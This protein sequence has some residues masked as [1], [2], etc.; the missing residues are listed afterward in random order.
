MFRAQLGKRWSRAWQAH[1]PEKMLRVLPVCGEGPQANQMQHQKP[2]TAHTRSPPGYGP[3]P[4]SPCV[5]QPRRGEGG[6]S[7][8][9]GR[10]TP[11]ASP[12][13]EPLTSPCNFYH[14]LPSPKATPPRILVLGVPPH[15]SPHP[16]TRAPSTLI[17][18]PRPLCSKGLATRLQKTP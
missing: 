15:V 5:Q 6:P 11:W 4:P 17:S 16:L 18:V 14:G 10:P 7:G 9:P 12:R 8:L 13:L 2:D 1:G 3:F